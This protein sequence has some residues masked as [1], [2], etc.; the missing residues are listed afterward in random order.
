[1]LKKI[2]HKPK[3]TY[4]Q[5]QYWDGPLLYNFVLNGRKKVPEIEYHLLIHLPLVISYI[6]DMVKCRWWDG[7]SNPMKTTTRC[8]GGLLITEK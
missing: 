3:H 4:R 5:T 1:M 7:D 6:P 8:S 2:K